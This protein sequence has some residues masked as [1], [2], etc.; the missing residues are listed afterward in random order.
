MDILH[1]VTSDIGYGFLL[2]MAMLSFEQIKAVFNS[3][4]VLGFAGK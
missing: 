2:I 3:P 1:T 4:D